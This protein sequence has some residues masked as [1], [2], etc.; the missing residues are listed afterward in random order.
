MRLAYE[1]AYSTSLLFIPSLPTFVALDDITFRRP[2]PIGS[3]LSLTAQ[4]VYSTGS[5]SSTFQVKVRADVVD[6]AT[7]ESDTS[8]TFHFTFMAKERD[9]ETGVHDLPRVMPRSYDE[10]TPSSR[11]VGPDLG[12][13]F[14]CYRCRGILEIASEKQKGYGVFK[15]NEQKQSPAYSHGYSTYQ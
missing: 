1:L 5:P 8:N 9:G 15:E 7:R 6:P 3:L 4:V 10:R 11:D 14:F 13:H 2:V 12:A